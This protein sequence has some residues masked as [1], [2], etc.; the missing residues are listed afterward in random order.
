L[1]DAASAMNRARASASW[2][3]SCEP[4]NSRPQ[5]RHCVFDTSEHIRKSHRLKNGHPAHVLT[6]EDRRKA[7][8]GRERDPA[9]ETPLA[10]SAEAERG[11]RADDGC[12]QGPARAAPRAGPSPPRGQTRAGAS[13]ALGSPP[14]RGRDSPLASR[15]S[16]FARPPRVYLDSIRPACVSRPS[17]LLGSVARRAPGNPAL[18]EATLGDFCELERRGTCAAFGGTWNHRLEAEEID[19]PDEKDPDR[20][21]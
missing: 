12:G 2:V 1:A 5:R 21:R 7:G 18:I 16:T 14:A 9:R 4:K 3:C 13:G 8:R 10:R 17:G 15:S 20:R 6:T 11:D 19:Q